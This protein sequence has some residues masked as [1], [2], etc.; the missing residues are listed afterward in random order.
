MIANIGNIHGEFTRKR[1]LDPKIP[2]SNPRSSI[3]AVE[4]QN[5]TRPWIT[6]N[7]IAAFHGG[8]KIPRENERST[9]TPRP[10]KRR[11]RDIQSGRQN[12]SSTRR[13]NAVHYNRGA[14]RN[15]THSQGRRV[16]CVLLREEGVHGD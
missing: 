15:N 3:V 8:R 12:R 5:R 6:S 9:R 7:A 11:S 13:C 4:S 14:G 2:Y 16:I 1:M 10:I